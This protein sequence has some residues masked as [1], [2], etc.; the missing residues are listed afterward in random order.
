MGTWCWR[1]EKTKEEVECRSRDGRWD[2][3]DDPLCPFQLYNSMIWPVDRRE[4]GRPEKTRKLSLLWVEGLGSALVRAPG[5]VEGL[6]RKRN[7]AN[8]C[9][10]HQFPAKVVTKVPHFFALILHYCWIRS[11]QEL[12]LVPRSPGATE[13]LACYPLSRRLNIQ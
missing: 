10:H 7:S 3:L 1:M 12:S 4:V 13:S 2:W 6:Y 9:C 8:D 5:T 11:P